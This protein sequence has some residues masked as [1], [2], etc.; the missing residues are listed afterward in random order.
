[1]K[2]KTLNSFLFFIISIFSATGQQVSPSL[3]PHPDWSLQSN[4]Y[5]VNVR[6]Y[7]PEGTFKAFEKHLPRLK[8][9]GVEILWFM[10][11]T[12]IGIKGRK[13]TEAELGSYYAVRDYKAVNPEFG[14][15]E[16]F[17]SLV[18]KAH[19]MGFKVITD[20]V[21]NHTALD[22]KW[23]Q[24]RPDFYVKDS[25]GNF[26]SPFD[27][28]DVLKLDYRNKVLWDS[29]TYAMKWWISNTG[30]D[31][32]RCDVAEE[33]GPDFWKYNIA[34][35]K[36]IKN[37]FMLAEGQAPWCHE[38]GFDATYQWDAMRQ[39]QDVTSGKITIKEFLATLEKDI[40][41]YPVDAQR[42]YF[43]TNHDE[44]SWNGTEFEKYGDAAQALAVLTQTMYQSIPLVYSGQEA[45]NRKRLKFFVKDSISW[46]SLPY[47]SFY[48]TLLR[49]RRANQAL[50]ADAEWKIIPT[51]KE[52]SILAFERLKGN[53]RVFVFLNLSGSETAFQL[54]SSNVEGVMKNV[55]TG[56]R[57]KISHDSNLILKGYQWLV[58][59]TIR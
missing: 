54:M 42:M 45:G 13:M 15:L 31:G 41:K 44:N 28:T 38:V 22:N 58:L 37:V 40:S 46:E 6:Q 51:S 2:I 52:K 1:M 18:K 30:I 3:F 26:V 12:P 53:D 17:K 36:K 10:P 25:S 39:M 23:T 11:I 56:S 8:K 24:T 9:M 34:E 49:L 50:S 5:E 7:T 16:D 55:F 14:S 35:L 29:M 19:K 57:E 48:Q 43:T 59:E 20:W 4:I 21:A 27:W 47:A 32:F 33:V